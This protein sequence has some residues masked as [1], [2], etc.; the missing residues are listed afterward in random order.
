MSEYVPEVLLVLICEFPERVRVPA[1]IDDVPPEDWV[2]VRAPPV[3]ASVAVLLF[4][5]RLSIE[6]LVLSVTV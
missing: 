2:N 3:R 5:I 6:S 1:V 4:R